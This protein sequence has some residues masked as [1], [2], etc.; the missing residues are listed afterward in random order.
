MEH[1]SLPARVVLATDHAGFRLKEAVKEYLTHKGIDIVDIGTFSEE[2]VDYPAI[3]RRG[4]AA[5]LEQQCPGIIFGGSGNGEA[6]AA[7]KVR[8]IRAAVGYSTEIARLAR[9]HNDANILSLGGRFVDPEL[10][11]EMVEIFLTT[12]FDGGRHERRVQDLE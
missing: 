9:A 3:I 10:A 5:V 11:I 4:C 1:M 7:N 2:S 8:G 12:A 6:I